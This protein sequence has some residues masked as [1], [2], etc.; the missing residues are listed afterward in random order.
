M[1]GVHHCG[2]Q[3]GVQLT[4]GLKEIAEAIRDIDGDL[5]WGPRGNE[6]VAQHSA[7]SDDKDIRLPRT[8]TEQR[9]LSAV[10][11]PAEEFHG[12]L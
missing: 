7:P 2:P 10:T 3:R 9:A 11:P 8:G 4:A 12:K 5:Q 1:D 6:N